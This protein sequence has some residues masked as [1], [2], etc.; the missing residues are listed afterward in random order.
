[1][2]SL[3]LIRPLPSAQT[4]PT[5]FTSYVK[6]VVITA[7]GKTVRPIAPSAAGLP[8]N[9]VQLGVASGL[10]TPGTVLVVTPAS[11]TNPTPLLDFSILQHYQSVALPPNALQPVATAVI[12]INVD[13]SQ[14]AEFPPGSSF[15][16]SLRI[17]RNGAPIND[18]TVEYNITPTTVS[19]LSL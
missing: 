17:T 11:A 3:L 14:T 5:D 4:N 19:A 9:T 16:V 18:D 8:P 1:M 13:P 6:D 10:A 2:G 7:F 15:N 12:V